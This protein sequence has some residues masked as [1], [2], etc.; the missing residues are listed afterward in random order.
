MVSSVKDIWNMDKTGCFWRALPDK[1][2]REKRKL[3]KRGKK[4]KQRAL[5][6]ELLQ[7]GK[8]LDG[9]RHYA[10]YPSQGKQPTEVTKPLNCAAHG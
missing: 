5:P 6:S 3:C 7:S 9:R 10:P 8:V 4:C 1:G 2:L